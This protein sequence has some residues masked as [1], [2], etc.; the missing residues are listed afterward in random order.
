MPGTYF[1]K[2]RRHVIKLE[3]VRN[4]AYGELD[5][6]GFRMTAAILSPVAEHLDWMKTDAGGRWHGET[7]DYFCRGSDLKGQGYQG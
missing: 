3:C 7:R 6:L 1:D 5:C 4:L 2:Q